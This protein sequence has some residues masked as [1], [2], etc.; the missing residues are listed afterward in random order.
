MMKAANQLPPAA[1][2]LDPRPNALVDWFD[3]FPTAGNLS[4]SYPEPVKLADLLAMQNA[5]EAEEWQELAMGYTSATGGLPLRQE[6][7]TACRYSAVSPEQVLCCVPDEGIFLALMALLQPGTRVVVTCPAY[8]SLFELAHARG[9]TLVHWLPAEAGDNDASGRQPGELWFDP[10][11][12][13]RLVGGGDAHGPPTSLV[14]VNFPHNPTGCLPTRQEQLEMVEICRAGGGG[15]GGGNP[16]APIPCFC[17][18]IYR[19]L[20]YR[21]D[22]DRLPAM[23][24]VYPE[25]GL[26]LG[27]LSKAF[28]LPG[29]RIGWLATQNPAVLAQAAKL[30]TYTTICC[31]TPNELLARTALR[32]GDKLI[33]R[34]LAILADNLETVERFFL[35]HPAVFEQ[36]F[37]RPRAGTVAFPKLTERAAAAAAAALA[38]SAPRGGDTGPA[39][40]TGADAYCEWLGS[41]HQLVLVPPA[42]LSPPDVAA[43][44]A[45]RLGPRFRVGFGRETLP[46]LLQQWGQAI[47]ADAAMAVAEAEAEAAAV[48]ARL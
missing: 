5:E 18:E 15:G 33:A 11:E 16:A 39:T 38:A 45:E 26:S 25:G 34:N 47:A 44:L 1:L 42:A 31:G 7:V 46:G 9:C 4:P 22:T 37:V 28:A 21:P 35:A 27:G 8:N 17:D 19:L 40:A 2:G 23:C 30:K 14:V 24:D 20:E 32:N 41:V 29:L 36:P 43:V 48:S 6:I 13:R 10:A 3:K 12:L